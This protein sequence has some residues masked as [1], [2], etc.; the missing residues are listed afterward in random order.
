[1]NIRNF[2]ECIILSLFDRKFETKNIRYKFEIFLTLL[3]TKKV[4]FPSPFVSFGD[5]HL[6]W[7][8]WTPGKK[9][10]KNSSKFRKF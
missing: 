3:G 8:G 9:P 4:F 6:F 10:Q 7:L 1:M 2:S 5:S